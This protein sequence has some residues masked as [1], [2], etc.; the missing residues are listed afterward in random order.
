MAGRPAAPQFIV[1]QVNHDL[2]LA[3]VCHRDLV[4]A[5]QDGLRAIQWCAT[6]GLLRN[7]LMCENCNIPMSFQSRA[8]AAFVD[9]YCW[10]CKTCRRQRSLR[11]GSFFEGSHLRLSQ[12]ID[13]IY[14]WSIDVRQGIARAECGELS[15]KTIVDWYDIIIYNN[16]L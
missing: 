13:L 15:S 4:I 3:Q 8:Q 12:L 9:G 11:L 7:S 1:A 5:T 2:L 6:R 16:N 14:W 10:A